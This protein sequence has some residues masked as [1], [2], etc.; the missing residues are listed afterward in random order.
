VGV[1]AHTVSIYCLPYASRGEWRDKKVFDFN[2]LGDCLKRFCW[3]HLKAH[4]NQME[5]QIMTNE[6][7]HGELIKL[8]YQ[9]AGSALNNLDGEALRSLTSQHL[10][11]G[12]VLE[13]LGAVTAG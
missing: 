6:E 4:V 12:A 2:A 11:I 3:L 9:L 8:T 13:A 1:T 7:I 5:P 10:A